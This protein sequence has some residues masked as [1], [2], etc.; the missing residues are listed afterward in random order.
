M[1]GHYVEANTFTDS[2]HIQNVVQIKKG[3]E[4]RIP[5]S[6][7]VCSNR[8]CHSLRIDCTFNQDCQDS[9]SPL[10]GISVNGFRPSI[11]GHAGDNQIAIVENR[12][13]RMAERIAK[14]ALKP[15]DSK[16]NVP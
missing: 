10:A 4:R 13:E 8:P 14:L 16:R 5:F 11:T 9:A 15:V 3:D 7:V 12:S 1:G 6:Y 2:D